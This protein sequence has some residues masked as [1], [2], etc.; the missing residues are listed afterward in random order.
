MRNNDFATTGFLA[1]TAAS[2]ILLC[3]GLLAIA[4]T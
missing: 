2:F 1:L 4:F 3:S